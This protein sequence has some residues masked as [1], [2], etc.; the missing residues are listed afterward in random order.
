MPPAPAAS[1]DEDVTAAP[2]AG[3]SDSLIDHR[4][5]GSA[6]VVPLRRGHVLV[7]CCLAGFAALGF[8][9]SDELW[10][11]LQP[12][13]QRPTCNGDLVY[14]SCVA[15]CGLTCA[16]VSDADCKHPCWP[17]CTCPANRPVLADNATCVA[18][19]QDCPAPT[20]AP[21]SRPTGQPAT[22]PPSFV[23]PWVPVNN[24]QNSVDFSACAKAAKPTAAV[25]L[26]LPPA[27]TV[28][29]AR[30]G[31]SPCPGVAADVSVFFSIVSQQSC[32]A[33][34]SAV[35][36]SYVQATQG[37]QPAGSMVPATEY[38][39]H[40]SSTKDFAR[41]FHALLSTLTPGARYVYEIGVEGAKANQTIGR[42]F[43][44]PP[45]PGDSTAQ[46]NQGFVI[47]DTGFRAPKDNSF[48]AMYQFDNQVGLLLHVG[49]LSYITNNG[50]C[51]GHN[52]FGEPYGLCGFYC[53]TSCLYQGRHTDFATYL[54]WAS[55]VDRSLGGRIV[56]MTTMGNHDNDPGWFMVNRPPLNAALPGVAP[57][58]FPHRLDGMAGFKGALKEKLMDLVA[59]H[60]SEP[61]FYSFDY[62]LAHVIV[63]G[64]EDNANNAY[65]RWDGK[66]LSGIMLDRFSKHF[67]VDS[68]QYAFVKADLA[69]ANA[70]E[71]RK[72]VPWV[73]AMTHRPMYHT[74]SH[75]PNCGSGGDWSIC[76]VRDLYEPVFHDYGVDVLFSGHS[77]HYQRST[78]VFKGQKVEKGTTHIIVGAGGFELLGE[79][80]H[81]NPPW[82]A[83]RQSSRFGYGHYRIVNETHMFWEYLAF[84]NA[85][86]IDSAWVVR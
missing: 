85:T 8:A 18:S 86:V 37:A 22:L 75:H 65:E 7:V 62:G 80:W 64:T 33:T 49:D 31:L 1:F 78:P 56:W 17:G 52:Q 20:A 24:N 60:L 66:P 38:F 63:Y 26:S 35:K 55:T 81:G 6:R 2:L 76:M 73:I 4:G 48:Q 36:V 40:P 69:R 12:S 83:Y 72:K 30:L 79:H 19:L 84:V 51:W 25:P 61:F 5:N 3:E 43:T 21:S 57:E 71:Q 77:H 27:W 46:L 29:V 45:L 23:H 67:G 54:S 50:G 74:A 47:G 41:F 11:L 16:T 9:F 39:C 28:P 13:E 34:F 59:R 32:N 53:N 15:P 70:P 44:A 10:S 82:M 14:S 42:E 68:A 58:Q